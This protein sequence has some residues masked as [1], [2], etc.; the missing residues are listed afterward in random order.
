MRH[1]A[2]DGRRRGVRGLVPGR[3]LCQRRR[4]RGI[5]CVQLV[6]K[7]DA[8]CGVW[9]PAV[10]RVRVD[11]DVRVVSFVFSSRGKRVLPVAWLAQT[12]ARLA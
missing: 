8:G 7:A 3:G 1:R 2:Y 4:P 6:R 10:V 12:V 9:C 11:V 5:L